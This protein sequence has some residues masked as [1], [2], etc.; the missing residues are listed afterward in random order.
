M[1]DFFGKPVLLGYINGVALIVIALRLGKLLGV[2]VDVDEF[3]PIIKEV[4][5]GLDDANGP[6]VLK[7]GASGGRARRQALSSDGTAVAH[8]PR[9]QPRDRGHG[10]SRGPRHSGRR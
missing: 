10:G 9:A 4:I 1:A 7:C 3:F 8:R 2:T 6:T 5:S